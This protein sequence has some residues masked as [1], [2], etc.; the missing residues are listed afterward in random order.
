MI[1]NLGSTSEQKAAILRDF[2]KGAAGC[3]VVPCSIPSSVASQPL[4]L[5]ET[6]A[7]ARNRARAAALVGAGCDL[8]VGMEGGLELKEGVYHM[9]CVVHLRDKSGV[10]AEGV[11]VPLVLPTAVSEGIIS[12]GEF[13]RLIRDYGARPGLSQEQESAAAVY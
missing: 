6:L 3:E 10:E 1:I 8:A 4:S 5:N 12:G 11:S 13:S 2:F 7:G 9:V